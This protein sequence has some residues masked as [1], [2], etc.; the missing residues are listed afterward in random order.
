[1]ESYPRMHKRLLTHSEQPYVQ[2]RLWTTP[3]KNRPYSLIVDASTGT[4]EI[5]GGL[6]AILTQQDE[7][8]EERVIA[9][10]S[11]QLLKHEKNYTPFLIEMQAI[12][13]ANTLT[14]ISGEENLR[15]SVIT[16]H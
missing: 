11:R 2:N 1:M 16:N 15:C 7:N 4:A 12:V 10:A 5:A 13:W 8:Q 6:G 14:L 9:H 3:E